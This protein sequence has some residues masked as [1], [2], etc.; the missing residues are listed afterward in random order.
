MHLDHAM[1]WVG[2][3]CFVSLAVMDYRKNPRKR[4][5]ILC[6]L[7]PPSLRLSAFL[8]FE[9][10]PLAE[11]LTGCIPHSAIYNPHSNAGA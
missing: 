10:V 6:Q 9:A 8:G 11:Y 7:L 4:N 5:W 3:A 1:R 2:C